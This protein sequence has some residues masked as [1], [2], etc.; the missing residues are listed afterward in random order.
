MKHRL[1]PWWLLSGVAF[2]MFAHA[3]EAPMQ[4]NAQQGDV[5]VM[6]A[7]VKVGID[8]KTGRLRPVT[9]EES[10][11]LSEAIIGKRALQ[12][13]PAHQA[14]YGVQPTTEQEVR[15][16]KRTRADGSVA[17]RAPAS[18]MTEARAFIDANGRVVVTESDASGAAQG[19]DQ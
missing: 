14:R 6:V 19:E 10:K 5:E 18:L 8:P 2:A 15:S 4:G 17:V 1:S 7:N 13:A 11:E 12:R 16:S 3:A 9:A